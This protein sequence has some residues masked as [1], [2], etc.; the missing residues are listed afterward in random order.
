MKHFFQTQVVALV[1][2]LKQWGLGLKMF[3]FVMTDKDDETDTCECSWCWL[4]SDGGG[5]VCLYEYFISCSQQTRQGFTPFLFSPLKPK[6]GRNP[7][8]S[9]IIKI[10]QTAFFAEIRVLIEKG[11]I[12]WLTS[13][14]W[15][16]S[17]RNYSPTTI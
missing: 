11:P 1:M 9:S 12:V 10:Y 4:L 2:A 8:T 3:F 16:I 17:V 7:T 5:G 15:T 6:L 14:A 13:T